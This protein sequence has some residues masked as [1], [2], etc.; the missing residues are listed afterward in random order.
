MTAPEYD[1]NTQARLVPA[2]VALHSFIQAH[3]S[4]TDDM[5]VP[6]T[7]P[8]PTGYHH[9]Q[10]PIQIGSISNEEKQQASA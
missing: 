1:I 2:T 10:L 6:N 9:S 7:L 3:S 5:E 4:F 8:E